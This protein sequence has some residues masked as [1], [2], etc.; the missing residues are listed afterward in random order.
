VGKG[1]FVPVQDRKSSSSTDAGVAE[2]EL[3]AALSKFSEYFQTKN[4]LKKRELVTYTEVYG[5]TWDGVSEGQETTTASLPIY[6]KSDQDRWKFLGVVAIDVMACALELAL[7]DSNPT[8]Q[9]PPAKPEATKFD[10]CTCA[11]S[12]TYNGQQFTG[13]ECTTLDWPVA[14]CATEG[15]GIPTN[16]DS[17]STGFWADCK[18][19]GARAVLEEQLRKS[20][21]ECGKDPLPECELEALR[22]ADTKCRGVTAPQSELVVSCEASTVTRL[23]GYNYRTKLP[24]FESI[25]ESSWKGNTGGSYDSSR[26]NTD[27]SSCDQCSNTDMQPQCALPPQCGKG[28]PVPVRAGLAADD[29]V[30]GAGALSPVPWMPH[31][32]AAAAALLLGLAA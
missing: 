10:G 3:T 28:V 27:E 7:L 15:C 4:T 30:A 2:F 20:G 12:Y 5:M 6:D 32:L 11:E 17:I 24:G 1:V 31:L 29:A 18:P 22:P 14:W 25:S 8:I 26:W 16:P 21:E 9:D 23:E 19:F 13:G